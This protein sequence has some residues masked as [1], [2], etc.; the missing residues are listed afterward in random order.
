MI[1]NQEKREN[2]IGGIY[3]SAAARIATLATKIKIQEPVMMTGG[4]AKN[5]GVVKAVESRF[6]CQILSTASAQEYG[7]IGAAVFAENY[8]NYG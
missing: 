6:K 5:I 8:Q 3:E 7:A 1:E 2:I 4:V